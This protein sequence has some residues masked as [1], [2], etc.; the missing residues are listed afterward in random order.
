MNYRNTALAGLVAA[1]LIMGVSE[2]VAQRTSAAGTTDIKPYP[3]L[4]KCVVASPRAALVFEPLPIDP[5]API[6]EKPK[7]DDGEDP[8][9]EPIGR[10]IGDAFNF[11][12]DDKAVTLRW[13]QMLDVKLSDRIEGVWYRH[14]KGWLGAVLILDI[15]K[16]DVEPDNELTDE[17]DAW[18]TLGRDGVADHRVG[19]S[20]GKAKNI[21]VRFY[22]TRPGGY[23][24]RARVYTYA[25]PFRPLPEGEEPA[26]PT[27]DDIR[28]FGRVAANTVYIKVRVVYP[29]VDVPESPEPPEPGK[30]MPAEDLAGVIR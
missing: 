28:E 17:E 16:P 27:P 18:V 7:L 4:V 15:R 30:I 22:P 1:V 12:H 19:P 24:L 23:L 25:L 14:A 13:G 11:A 26:P 8:I 9:P 10:S 21:G 29:T 20:I 3:R 6:P 2:G 5:V